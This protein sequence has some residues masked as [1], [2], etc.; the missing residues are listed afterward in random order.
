M[1]KAA[2]LICPEI[3]P[4]MEFF[5]QE[6]PLALL[7][8]CGKSLIDHA[9]CELASQGFQKIDL[10]LSDRPELLREQLRG[11]EK[12][13]VKISYHPTPKEVT[14]SDLQQNTNNP[15]E[16]ASN[17]PVFTLDRIP[18]DSA[19]SLFENHKSLFSQLQQLI[20]SAGRF[21]L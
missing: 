17:T 13:G 3:R 7:S 1:T 14:Q 19:A 9:L 10:Y 12:W 18:L 5:K 11:G 8:C 21:C 16:E 15:S 6:K 2:K 4:G 20:A